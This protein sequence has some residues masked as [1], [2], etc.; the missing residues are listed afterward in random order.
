[1]FS[2]RYCGAAIAFKERRALNPDGTPHALSCSRFNLFR[3]SL[4]Q[5]VGCEVPLQRDAYESLNGRI[6][7][8]DYRVIYCPSCNWFY[9]WRVSIN[10]VNFGQVETILRQMTSEQRWQLHHHEIEIVE[11]VT[12]NRFISSLPSE[13][14]IPF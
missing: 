9:E 5:C 14:Q 3:R 12:Y 6:A 10:G 2:C 1:M 4:I 13:P 7:D 8:P 11:P